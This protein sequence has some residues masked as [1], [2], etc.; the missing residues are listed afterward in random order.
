MYIGFSRCRAWLFPVAAV[1]CAT[2]CGGGAVVC[3]LMAELAELARGGQV[4]NALSS[5]AARSCCERRMAGGR[6][7]DALG[8]QV[9]VVAG[10]SGAQCEVRTQERGGQKRNTGSGRC[11]AEQVRARR[12]WCAGLGS[13]WA[14]CAGLRTRSVAGSC[15][16]RWPWR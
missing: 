12:G 11:E 4:C 9:V 10:Q 3:E 13:K 2:A 1:S 15:C 16:G 5:G 6:L 8:A 14:R 7:G